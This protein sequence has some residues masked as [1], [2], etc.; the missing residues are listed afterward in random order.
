MYLF[1]WLADPAKRHGQTRWSHET[2]TWIVAMS[3]SERRIAMMSV[4]QGR[5]TVSSNCT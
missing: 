2:V 5:L 1:V 3:V 4:E